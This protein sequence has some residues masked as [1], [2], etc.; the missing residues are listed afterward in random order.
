MLTPF[1]I[2]IGDAKKCAITKPITVIGRS[3]QQADIRIDDPRVSARHCELHFKDNVLT[4]IDKSK[5][6]TRVNDQ[7]IDETI[8]KNGDLLQILDHEYR[9][10]WD[11]KVAEM[12]Q[13]EW[14]IRMAGMEL[15]PLGWD[16]LEAMVQRGEVQPDDTVAPYDTKEWQTVASLDRM[17][18][19]V[20]QASESTRAENESQDVNESKP[21]TFSIESD[22]AEFELPKTPDK[23]EAADDATADRNLSPIPSVG[24]TIGEAQSLT[25]TTTE[26]RADSDEIDALKSDHND[27]VEKTPF[28]KDASNDRLEEFEPKDDGVKRSEPFPQVEHEEP[29]TAADAYF[30]RIGPIEDGPLSLAML[31]QL[32]ANGSLTP[33]SEVR[34]EGR[35]WVTAASVQNLFQAD[36][37]DYG[38]ASNYDVSQLADSADGEASTDDTNDTATPVRTNRVVKFL[39]PSTGLPD[40]PTRGR[41][42]SHGNVKDWLR[43]AIN[44]ARASRG[45][46]VV[47]VVALLC[48][49]YYLVPKYQGIQVRG[50]VTLDGRPMTK[51]TIT[52]RNLDTGLGTTVQIADDGNYEAVTLEGGLQPGTYKVCFM[53]S[54][55][56]P[57]EIVA[58]LQQIFQEQRN[59][60]PV[61]E[62]T[63]EDGDTKPE[64]KKTKSRLP[65]GTIPVKYRSIESSGLERDITSDNK[66]ISFALKSS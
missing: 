12:A 17:F 33:L 5:H 40:V 44:D 60:E 32:V 14:L 4:I 26:I 19:D 34:Q 66:P 52:F 62:G 2:P 23:A 15:G 55:P 27:A 22:T 29:L 25:E 39:G 45:T 59:P 58:K 6:G 49:I 63:Y 30:Y 35:D 46:V 18:Q 36:S 56:E 54:D 53:P 31:R 64:Y 8:L 47:L 20:A 42:Q 61:D 51:A 11:P 65:L 7:S 43:G 9:V 13:T 1:L 10:D 41:S 3:K 37:E 21:T 16:E 24:D 57:P 28:D 50:M 38:D 48:V